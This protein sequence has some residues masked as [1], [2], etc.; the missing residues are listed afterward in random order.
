MSI[1]TWLYAWL[2]VAIL[3]III[4]ILSPTF[5]FMFVSGAAL[6][7]ALSAWLGLS[8]LWQLGLFAVTLLITLPLLRPRLLRR[9]GV[10]GSG[11]PSRTERLVGQRGRVS[12]AIDPA[13]G[14]GRVLISGEDWAARS[15]EPVAAGCEIVV[16]G[17]DGIVLTVSPAE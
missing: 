3:A 12:E 15:P 11:V 5:G 8:H 1:M 2:I 7:S 9:F 4:E 16:D 6:A 17:A 14:T 13:Q 10:A